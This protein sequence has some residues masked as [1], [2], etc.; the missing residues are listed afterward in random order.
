MLVINSS[1]MNIQQLIIM[2]MVIKIIRMYW[3]FGHLPDSGYRMLLAGFWKN[4][5]KTG[6]KL[7][8]IKIIRDVPDVTLADSGSGS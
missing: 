8:V 1:L 5:L 7:P 3:I 6:D 4:R 2:V